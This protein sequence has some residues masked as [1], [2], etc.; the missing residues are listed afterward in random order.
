MNVFQNYPTKCLELCQVMARFEKVK[1]ELR[2]AQD[3]AKADVEQGRRRLEENEPA[4]AERLASAAQLQTDNM[5]ALKEAMSEAKAKVLEEI[6][7]CEAA[8]E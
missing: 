1:A 4:T 8:L 2:R 3:E 6:R 7:K 5:E